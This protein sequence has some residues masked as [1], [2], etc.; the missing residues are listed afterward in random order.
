VSAAP[1]DELLPGELF[2]VV[3]MDIEGSEYFAFL[4]MQRILTAAIV[5]VVEFIPHHLRNVAG[6]SVAEFLKPIREHFTTL[7]V[8]YNRLVVGRD[9]FESV[10]TLMYESDEACAAIIFMKVES[11]DVQFL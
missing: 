3:Q 11:G 2:D 9:Q 10:L 6:I 7:V 8:P 4:G 5:L 1:L